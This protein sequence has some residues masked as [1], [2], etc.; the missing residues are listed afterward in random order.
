MADM[1]TSIITT[2][3]TAKPAATSS[4]L[5]AVHQGGILEGANPSKFNP[6]DPITMFI[7]QVCFFSGSGP[8]R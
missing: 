8:P 5:R 7:I 1:I 6:K 3:V 4:S 2:T